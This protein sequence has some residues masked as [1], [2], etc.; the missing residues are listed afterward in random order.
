MGEI[1]TVVYLGVQNPKIYVNFVLLIII[2]QPNIIG[3][4]IIGKIRYFQGIYGLYT[5]QI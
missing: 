5:G 4:S 3:L 2:A 1:K